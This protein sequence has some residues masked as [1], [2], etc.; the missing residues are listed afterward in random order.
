MVA[1]PTLV[2][3]RKRRALSFAT[4]SAE[5]YALSAYTSCDVLAWF[6]KPIEF[7]TVM[8]ARIG[9]VVVPDQLVLGIRI[10]MVL[11]AQEALAAHPCLSAGFSPGSCP[12]PP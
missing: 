10:H 6:H 1:A 4:F 3:L 7:L 8:C 9:H 12:L 5:R 11:V 2:R